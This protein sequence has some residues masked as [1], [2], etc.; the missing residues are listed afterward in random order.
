MGF[1]DHKT[2]KPDSRWERLKSI[3]QEGRFSRGP[4]GNKKVIQVREKAISDIRGRLK[5]FF[6]IE[7]D[8]F[9]PYR[10]HR[11]WVPKFEIEDESD[12]HLEEQEV[13]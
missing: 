1:E 8:P 2:K 10:K 6:E 5:Q 13:L 12:P 7:E 4:A 9:F 11:A 3:A